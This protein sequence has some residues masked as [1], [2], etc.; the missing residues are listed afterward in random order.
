MVGTMSTLRSAGETIGPAGQPDG[1]VS[2]CRVWMGDACY[3]NFVGLGSSGFIPSVS[4]GN[5][6]KLRLPGVLKWKR[7]G[8]A[9]RDS[10]N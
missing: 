6:Q 3:L 4:L 7:H 5:P 1:Y 10:C 2:E 8:P 9:G